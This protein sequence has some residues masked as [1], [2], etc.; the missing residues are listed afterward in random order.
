LGSQSSTLLQ[1][2]QASLFHPISLA[3]VSCLACLI[4]PPQS[5]RRLPGT[6]CSFTRVFHRPKTQ[7]CLFLPSLPAYSVPPK[8]S[9]RKQRN[10]CAAAEQ[11]IQARTDPLL[12]DGWLPDNRIRRSRTNKRRQNRGTEKPKKERKKG[13]L[14]KSRSRFC[15]WRAGWDDHHDPPF[16]DV[17][18]VVPPDH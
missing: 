5:R 11:M 1:G 14:P 3:C 17:F 9:E 4:I 18:H 13:K 2:G 15:S 16:Q 6:A 10:R 7:A 12:T 8:S